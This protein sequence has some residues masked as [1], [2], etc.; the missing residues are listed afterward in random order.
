MKAFQLP[1]GLLLGLGS[2]AF[3]ADGRDSLSVWDEWKNEIDEGEKPSAFH[4]AGHSKNIEEDIHLLKKM[5][6]KT[7][8]MGLEWALIEPEEG[9]LSESVVKGYREEILKWEKQGVKVLLV[10]FHHNNPLWFEEK[11]GWYSPQASNYFERY[12]QHLVHGLGDIQDEWITFHDPAR[13]LEHVFLKG[14][15]PHAQPGW[16]QY[17]GAVKNIIEAHIAAYIMIH[18]V[19]KLMARE[20]TKVSASINV[21]LLDATESS[22]LNSRG[23]SQRINMTQDIFLAGMIE[24]NWIPP[25]GREKRENVNRYCDFLALT[26]SGRRSYIFNRDRMSHF[27]RPLLRPGVPLD[28]IDQEIHPEG[29]KEMVQSVHQRYQLPVY[30]TALG[31]A[32]ARDHFRARFIYDHLLQVALLADE[33]VDVQR[34]Y[35]WSMFDGLE[36][37][38]G[39]KASYG[40]IR[41]K[42]D[43][44][45]EIKA[46]G[47]FYSEISRKQEISEAMIEKYL[48]AQ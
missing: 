19:R 33:G 25:L 30:I 16:N 39:Y 8:Y 17:I 10:L 43:A 37:E 35:Y 24:G 9:Q 5:H 6:Q 29:L 3:Q 31:V 27:S 42:K 38:N 23:L 47:R 26:Y 7:Y 15:W 28:D 46:S 21:D 32:D 22:F 36:W 34:L 1:P 41:V 18:N 44:K 11:G 45:R 40:L 2:S 20:N 12:V 13:Y 4:H 14:D 48:L